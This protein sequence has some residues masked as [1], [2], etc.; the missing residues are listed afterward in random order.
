MPCS[1]PMGMKLP[2]P[3]QLIVVFYEKPN[4][5]TRLSWKEEI[6]EKQRFKM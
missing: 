5:L 3:W 1:H 2:P 6:P 4:F